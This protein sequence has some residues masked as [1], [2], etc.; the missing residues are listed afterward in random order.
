MV[1]DVAQ[2]PEVSA[3]VGEELRQTL[4]AA[5]ETAVRAVR[6]ADVRTD[7]ARRSARTQTVRAAAA[8]EAAAEELRALAETLREPVGSLRESADPLRES[9]DPLRELGAAIDRR[10]GSAPAPAVKARTSRRASLRDSPLA[11][12]LQESGG[13]AARVMP[14]VE[15]EPEPEPLPLPSPAV[16]RGRPGFVE[17]LR[18]RSGR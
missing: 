12:M 3:D 18:R 14:H 5:H 11:S 1:T 7:R 15:P 13:P 16:P 9:A 6:A 10:N 4:D 8:I 17:N 2:A